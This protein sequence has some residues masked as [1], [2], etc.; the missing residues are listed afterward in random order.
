MLFDKWVS[1]SALLRKK[2]RTAHAVHH[3]EA[4]E[5]IV[6][7]RQPFAK[8]DETIASLAGRKTHH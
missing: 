5:S 3:G 1:Q 2:Q 4:V 7:I 6:L 8:A